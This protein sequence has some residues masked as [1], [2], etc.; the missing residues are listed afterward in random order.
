MKNG[1][2]V[3]F[4]TVL[5]WFL[6]QLPA[7][8]AAQDP[9][10]NLTEKASYGVGMYFGQQIK[11][12]NLLD[13]N[14]DVVMSAMK[15]VLEGREPKLTDQQSREAITAYQQQR[16]KEL[17]EKNVKEG[18][19]FLAANRTKPGVKTHTVTLAEGKT[20]EMQYKVITEGTGEMP[21]S[22]DVVKVNYRGTLVNGKE[23]DS[24]YKRGQPA[25]FAV[26]GVIRG[27]TEALQ[28][29]KTGSKWELYI[30]G[31]LAYAERGSPGIE[32]GSTLIFEVEL[33]EIEPPK[34]PPQPTTSDI[35]KVPSAEEMKAGAKIEVI[36]AADLEKAAAAQTNTA[37]TTKPTRK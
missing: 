6:V 21:K 16:Q 32:P 13:L 17:A 18:E 10:T 22:T 11:R 28:M 7:R 33:L 25:T 12:G 23:F 15:D 3:I 8:V 27:W 4:V 31:D 36:K 29:M 35:I 26:G 2:K 34:P 5:A 24:S 37:K 1:I 30:P 20:A 9:F 14:L 19:A